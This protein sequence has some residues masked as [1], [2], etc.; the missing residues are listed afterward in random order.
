TKP[1]FSV[2]QLKGRDAATI[3]ATIP[4]DGGL[5]NA[6]NGEQ[7][8]QLKIKGP[9]A[10]FYPHFFTRQAT[11]PSTPGWS[12]FA[13]G[14]TWSFSV[15]STTNGERRIQTATPSVFDDRWHTLTIVIYDSMV[16]N[17]NSRWVKRFTDGVRIIETGG[18]ETARNLGSNYG[19]IESNSPMLLGWGGDK[20]MGAA[21]FQAADVMIFNKA[22][23]DQEVKNNLCLQ[24]ITQH[25]KYNN[26]IG[27]WPMNDGGFSRTARNLAPGTNRP[28][29]VYDGVFQWSAGEAPCA[30]ATPGSG[31]AQ[32]LVK[33]VDLAANFFYWL[34][35][36][37]ATGWNLEGTK[38]LEQ[39]EIEFVK[40]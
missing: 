14:T 31:S 16:N 12:L 26:L 24:D 15:R 19:S 25:P 7:T 5:Y 34:R 9:N 17:V 37:A 11:W 39:Y 18:N 1:A 33:S 2:V 27:Y 4:N 6:G 32:V 35:I 30:G 13:S 22:L 8:I 10:G 38:W 40:L 23:T 28:D 21:A 36:T 3:K 20:G 29:F